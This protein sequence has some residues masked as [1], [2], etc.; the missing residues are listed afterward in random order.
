MNSP[1]RV[2]LADDHESVR[3]G[4]SAL[5]TAS[6]GLSLVTDVKDGGEAVAMVRTT[7]PDVVIMDLSMP[8]SGLVATK[9]IKTVRAETAVVV[10]SRHRD[11]AYVRAAFAAGATGYVLKQS[12]FSELKKAVLAAARGERYVDDVLVRDQAI[13]PADDGRPALSPRETEVL[14]RSAAGFSNKEIANELQISV[15]TVEA[16]KANAMRKLRL[17][18]R[19][20]IVRFALVQGWLQD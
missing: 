17:K 10:L 11:P 1:I 16:H 18:D 15:K 19:S 7:S 13:K 3:Q 5:F 8:T 20:A 4:L 6:P 12:P 9:Q 2:L 14:R